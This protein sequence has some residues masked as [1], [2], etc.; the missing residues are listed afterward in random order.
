MTKGRITLETKDMKGTKDY[1]PRPYKVEQKRFRALEQNKM[2]L[3][4]K[5]I[6]K[7]SS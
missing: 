6:I 2:N 4:G 5:L 3:E 1:N 7:V